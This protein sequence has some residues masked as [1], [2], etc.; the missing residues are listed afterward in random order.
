MRSLVDEGRMYC[1]VRGRGMPFCY[2]RPLR[3]LFFLGPFSK[4]VLYGMYSPRAARIE[5]KGWKSGWNV[6]LPA[7]V[8]RPS[9]QGEGQRGNR[10]GIIDG[11]VIRD[12]NDIN[13]L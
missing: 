7:A 4:E 13:Q 5:W 3:E 10:G 2:S 9:V 12:I 8:R 11:L 1:T 6:G